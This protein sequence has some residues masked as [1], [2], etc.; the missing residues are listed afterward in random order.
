MTKEIKN[1]FESLKLSE[2][3]DLLK[4]LKLYKDLSWKLWNRWK[5]LFW[6]IISKKSLYRVEYF[7]TISEKEALNEALFAYKKVFGENPETKDITLISKK[8]LD[9][10]IKIYKDDSLVDL[11]FKRLENILK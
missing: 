9:W 10:W 8:S 7:E 1:D 2:L 4:S 11:S 6:S 5:R 3:R